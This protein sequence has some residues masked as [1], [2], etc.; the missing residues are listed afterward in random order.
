MYISYIHKYLCIYIYTCKYIYIYVELYLFIH[1]QYN[2]FQCQA[3]QCDPFDS[4]PARL[5]CELQMLLGTPRP[6]HMP[7]R[8]PE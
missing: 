4:P 3:T 2:K 7:E 8:M 5:L 6:E 1:L